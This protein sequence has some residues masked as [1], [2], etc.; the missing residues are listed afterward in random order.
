MYADHEQANHDDVEVHGSNQVK[1]HQ[2]IDIHRSFTTQV[3]F[4]Q[5]ITLDD[6]T[7]TR[8]LTFSQLVRSSIRIDVGLAYDLLRQCWP[9]SKNIGQ[10]DLYPLLA[11]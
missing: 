5:V 10:G 4:N 3:T 6:F 7:K 1:L 11:R 8:N 9:N 2:S